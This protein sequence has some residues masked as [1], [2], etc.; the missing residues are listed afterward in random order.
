M[1]R[2]QLGQRDVTTQFD[3]ILGSIRISYALSDAI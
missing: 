1:I 2:L 3:I